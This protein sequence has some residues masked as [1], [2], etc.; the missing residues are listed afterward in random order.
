MPWLTSTRLQSM[1]W[2]SDLTGMTPVGCTA[3]RVAPSG[4][5]R[6]EHRR[7]ALIHPRTLCLDDWSFQIAG[8][9]LHA[10]TRVA[11]RNAFG[12]DFVF[13]GFFGREIRH[14]RKTDLVPVEFARR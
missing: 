3:K 13:H 6:N 14:R 9:K 10:H 8:T 5:P 7:R 1:A 4:A 11:H 12:R 2:R